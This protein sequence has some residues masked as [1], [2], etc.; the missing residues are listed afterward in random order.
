MQDQV[1]PET[2]AV[3]PRAGNAN[4]K[5]TY[6]EIDD[7]PV[8][9]SGKPIPGAKRKHLDFSRRRTGGAVFASENCAVRCGALLCG[10]FFF[11]AQNAAMGC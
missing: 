2:Y 4:R 5:K 1:R 11:L 7:N 6:R 10:V 3:A 8:Q 9:H